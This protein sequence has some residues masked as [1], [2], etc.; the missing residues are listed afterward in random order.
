MSVASKCAAW[1][2]LAP[3]VAVAAAQSSPL[4]VHHPIATHSPA[5]QAAFDRGLALVYAFNFQA[6]ERTF[7][8]AA[9]DDPS[10]AMPYWG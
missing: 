7:R 9:A 10:A 2:L 6:A 8:E 3:A 1:V 4:P 5:A